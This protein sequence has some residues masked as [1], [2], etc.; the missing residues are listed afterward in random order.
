[1]SFLFS[2]EIGIGI[3]ATIILGV[4]LVRIHAN[5]MMEAHKFK[6]MQATA[7]WLIPCALSI[8]G[9]GLLIFITRKV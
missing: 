3:L 1:L 7:S 6:L 9:V 4:Y 5:A 8:M 2:L